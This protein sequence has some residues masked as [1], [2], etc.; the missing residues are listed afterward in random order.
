MIAPGYERRPFASPAV[1][2][3]PT[4]TCAQTHTEGPPAQRRGARQRRRG[5]K[6]ARG[7][8][9]PPNARPGPCVRGDRLLSPLEWKAAG[10]GRPPP[11]EPPALRSPNMM[12]SRGFRMGETL[13][14]TRRRARSHT[15]QHIATKKM[16]SGAEVLWSWNSPNRCDERQT[17]AIG[18][19]LLRSGRSPT[20]RYCIRCD[21]TNRGD[22][23]EARSHNSKGGDGKRES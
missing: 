14:Q 5:M 2:H 1:L 19:Y 20:T 3:R 17:T 22:V 16:P 21:I 9:R 8:V 13:G 12:T 7:R 6:K 11:R 10:K 4:C 23:R 15:E 18:A